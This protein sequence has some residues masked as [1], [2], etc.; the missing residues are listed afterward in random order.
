MVLAPGFQVLLPAQMLQVRVEDRD[1]AG[2]NGCGEFVAVRTI[3]DEGADEARS[4][5]GLVVGKEC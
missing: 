4:V 2:V 5:G 3:A 1:V